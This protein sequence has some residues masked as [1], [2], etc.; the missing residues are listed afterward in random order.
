MEKEKET[1]SAFE[2]L[3]GVQSCIESIDQFLI[4]QLGKV[5]TRKAE[6]KHIV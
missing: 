6:V 5:G 2:I 3:V 4:A 1:V